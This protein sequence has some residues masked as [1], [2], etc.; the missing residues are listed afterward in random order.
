MQPLPGLTTAPLSLPDSSS[1]IDG[2]L[3][4]SGA[5]I[6]TLR[7]HDFS[8]LFKLRELRLN[9]NQIRRLPPE[10]F[11]DLSDLRLLHLHNNPGAPFPIRLRLIETRFEDIPGVAIE[12]PTA[13]PF[14]IDVR[15]FNEHIA[16][17]GAFVRIE[18]GKRYSADVQT[19]GIFGSDQGRI[20]IVDATSVPSD[21]C[22]GDLCW[23]GLT[24]VPDPT[25]LIVRAPQQDAGVHASASGLCAGMPTQVTVVTPQSFEHDAR[26]VRRVFAPSG[27]CSS[28]VTISPAPNRPRGVCT[29]TQYVTPTRH[30]AS[31]SHERE[32]D[33]RWLEIEHQSSQ[34]AIQSDTPACGDPGALTIIANA[35]TFNRRGRI[36]AVSFDPET[37][38]Y[39]FLSAAQDPNRAEPFT[40][41]PD[42]ECVIQRSQAPVGDCGA[43]VF[44]SGEGV[45]GIRNLAEAQAEV[46][47]IRPHHQGEEE[48]QR[49]GLIE[50][51]RQ[52]PPLS[53]TADA[54][55]FNEQRLLY[56][57][58]A[59]PD[60][61]CF[62]TLY[63]AANPAA[64]ESRV[65]AAGE[66]CT[67]S[68]TF[69]LLG[70]P[71]LLPTTQ[72]GDCEA[73]IHWAQFWPAEGDA[74]VEE[75]THWAESI[76]RQLAGTSAEEWAALESQFFCINDVCT[77]RPS[78]GAGDEE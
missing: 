45:G 55:S 30:G 41:S 9:D 27:Q 31:A 23:Q 48:A 28:A 35:E 26:I 8:G 21:R 56:A 69:Q 13:A 5:G 65:L 73:L 47:R 1:R 29:L 20:R 22:N 15:L 7:A 42:Q 25:A 60:E 10:L 40:F 11:A 64:D 4:L 19:G 36:D 12:V 16:L 32:G 3:D 2:A 75:I 38:C 43:I 67:I 63:V 39:S 24:I 52:L 78:A 62:I 53:V 44:W 72:T 74:S 61:L 14:P 51:C 70:F 50:A 77:L 46:A 34:G 58:G 71:Y 6:H 18:A 59:D 76:A 33:C 68:A 57:I 17:S 66:R 54:G 37:R 49:L